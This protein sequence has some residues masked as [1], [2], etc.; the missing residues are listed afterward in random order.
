MHEWGLWGHGG[1]VTLSLNAGK[2]FYSG[3]HFSCENFDFGYIISGVIE[4]GP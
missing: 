3:L 4:L 2:H 1:F